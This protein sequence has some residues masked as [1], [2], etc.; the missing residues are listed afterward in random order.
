MNG[1]GRIQNLPF[2]GLYQP[3]VVCEWQFSSFQ[4]RQYRL[5]LLNIELESS[6]NCENDFVL[7][8]SQKVCETSHISSSA[9]VFTNTAKVMFQTN[10]SVQGKGFIMQYEMVRQNAM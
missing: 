9:S 1:V 10:G 2:Y 4:G 6:P 5:R 8:N 3:D 7:I